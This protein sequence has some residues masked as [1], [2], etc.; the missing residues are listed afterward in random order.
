MKLKFL[1]SALITF[2]LA[3]MAAAQGLPADAGVSKGYMIGPGDQITG[4]VLG[5]DQFDFV[6]TVDEDGK[7]EVPFFDK[8]VPAIC[9]SERELRSDVTTL[10][11]KYLRTPQLS[12]RVTDRKSRPPAT[13]YGE[14]NKAMEITLMRK[15][16]LVEVLA[17]AGGIKEE[18]GGSVQIFR[19]QAPL[20]SD[21]T[22]ESNW[23]A[24]STDSTDVPSRT[25]SLAAVQLGKE[26]A[27]PT[28]YPGDVIMVHKAAPVYITGEVMA[29]Q[30]IYLKEG[31][32]SLTEAI[33][34]VSGVRP[35]AKTKDVKVYRLKPNASP[36]SKD[37][38]I[39][40]ANYDLIKKGQQKDIMLE[41]YDIIEVNKAKD[42]IASAIF[43]F[44][45]GAG[46]GLV[47]AS[48]NSIGYRVLY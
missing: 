38:E 19:T 23:K 31:G 37:R 47:M 24:D 41:P 16:S 27:N 20:C 28:I 22:D 21:A 6:A 2:V 43:K 48:S 42:S 1:F 39:I 30:G 33:A 8:P 35:E 13:I 9:R 46:K 44:A 18:A 32:M 7:I 12:L 5:E 40:S 17:I 10:L 34:K 26:E 29:P 14:V 45:I 15:A 3:G 4:K 11:A 25:Y 36:D